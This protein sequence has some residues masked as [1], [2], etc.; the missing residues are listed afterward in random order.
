VA[1]NPDPLQAGTNAQLTIIASV[2]GSEYVEVTQIVVTLLVG[3]NAKDFLSTGDGVATPVP[4]GWSVTASGGQF[5]YTPN[6]SPARIGRDGIAFE[7]ASLPVNDQIGTSI[8]AIDETASS[9]SQPSQDRTCTF[10]L[11]KFP[12]QFSVSPL[13]ASPLVVEYGG[14]TTLMWSGSPASYA[15]EYVNEQ[16]QQNIPVQNTGPYPISDLT[17]LPAVFTLIVTHQVPG[18]DHPLVFTEQVTVREQP[19]LAIILFEAS[20]SV[21][22]AG[23]LLTLTWQTQFATSVALSVSGVD[24]SIDVWPLASCNIISNDGATLTVSDPS[25]AVIGTFS[26][27]SPLP[28]TVTF[29]LTAANA[30]GSVQKPF[31]VQI[32]VVSIGYFGASG[33]GPFLIRWSTSGTAKVTLTR[34]GVVPQSGLIKT[35]QSGLFVLNAIGFGEPVQCQI[36]IQRGDLSDG[37]EPGNVL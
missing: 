9:V 32:V 35:V 30:T 37:D 36:R 1:R 26:V 13:S 16:G 27:P 22:G 7:L 33:N 12:Q 3:T 28:P 14:S 11:Q 29:N 20:S 17:I 18:S 31:E 2:I 24:G 23:Q 6:T 10:E 19:V 25:G 5:T 34:F 4:D 21:L 8:G 15:I